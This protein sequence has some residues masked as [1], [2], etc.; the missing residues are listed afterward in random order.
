MKAN[1]TA[2]KIITGVPPVFGFNHKIIIH[3]GL[4]TDA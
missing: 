2:A 4:E 1:K 3:P